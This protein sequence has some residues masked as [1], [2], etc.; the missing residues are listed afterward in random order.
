MPPKARKNDLSVFLFVPNIIGYIRI[1]FA[2]IAFYYI[3]NYWIFYIFY[4]LSALLDMADGYAARLLDQRSKFGAVL[5]MITDRASTSCLIVVL[6]QFYPNY[7]FF[8][9]FL[10]ALDLMSH[11]AHI[12]SSLSRGGEHKQTRKDQ[13]WLIQVYYNNRYFL[14]FLCAGNE[15]FFIFLYML[16]FIAGPVVHLG[17]LQPFVLQ[18][19]PAE[20]ITA[21]WAFAFLFCGPIMA[22]KQMMNF[23]QLKQAAVDLVELDDIARG[24]KV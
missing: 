5:D 23:I 7:L 1:I 15:G 10:I 16:K 8:F 14:A 21:V 18:Y 13:S 2:G 11:F 12:Y 20:H 17:P 24:K 6:A 3:E 4:S 22:F 9:L 19:L